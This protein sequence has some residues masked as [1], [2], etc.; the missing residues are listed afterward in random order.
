[1]RGARAMGTGAG[2]WRGQGSRDKSIQPV[3]TRTGSPEPSPKKTWL[4]MS[5]RKA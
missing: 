1:M 4:R 2:D 5:R 3:D